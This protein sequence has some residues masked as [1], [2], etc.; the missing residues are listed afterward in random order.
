MKNPEVRTG[1]RHFKINKKICLACDHCKVLFSRFPSKTQLEH[2]YCSMECYK[3]AQK[4][5][6][7]EQEKDKV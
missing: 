5:S 6:K 1:Y 3:A 2:H 4:L 7:S